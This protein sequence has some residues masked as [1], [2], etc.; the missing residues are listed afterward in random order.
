MP[1]RMELGLMLIPNLAGCNVLVVGKVFGVASC[2]GNVSKMAVD[3]VFV[4]VL[5]VVVAVGMLGLDIDS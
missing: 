3:I 5:V 4:A 2:F 1:M